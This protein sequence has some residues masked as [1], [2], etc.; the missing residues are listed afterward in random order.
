LNDEHIYTSEGDETG[1]RG[2]NVVALEPRTH[3]VLI[4]S[5]Y[6]TS[7]SVK[8]SRRLA[9]DLNALASGTIVMIAVKEDAVQ[10]L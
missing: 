1:G 10:S 9:R 6:D 7:T 5:S 3:N 2:F 8:Q 4:K